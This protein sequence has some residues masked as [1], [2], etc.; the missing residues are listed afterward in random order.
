MTLKGG[1][2]LPQRH[3]PVHERLLIGFLLTLAGGALDAYTYLNH[4]QV[5]AG[6]QTGNVILLTLHLAN[7][8]WPLVGHYLMPITAFALGIFATVSIEHFF[9]KNRRWQWQHIVLLL[10]I[11][12]LIAVA[13]LS[14]HWNDLWITCLISL[15]AALQYQTFRRIKGRPFTTIMATGNI[16]NIAVFLWLAL[17]KREPEKLHQAGESLL[18]VLAFMLGALIS[19]LLTPL[20][21]QLT[22]LFIVLDLIIILGILQWTTHRGL[23]Q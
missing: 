16:R 17:L 2:S 9:Q 1:T 12:G 15:V 10:E 22:V 3:D 6:L 5:F 4:G 20:W 19:G 21:H 18:I 11:I 13:L 7:G 23:Q 8:N 14:N